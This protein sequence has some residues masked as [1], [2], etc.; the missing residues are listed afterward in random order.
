TPHPSPPPRIAL[1]DFG[2]KWSILRNLEASGYEVLVFPYRTTSQEILDANCAGI[3][4]SNGPGD[5]AVLDHA[6]QEIGNLVR[7]KDHPPVLGICLGHQ[8]L[9]LAS[10][11]KTY[12]MKF[13]HHGVNHPVHDEES[14]RVWISSHNHGFSVD[15]DSLSGDAK[16]THISLNDR[17]V[18]GLEN[19]ILGYFSVQFHPESAPGPWEARGIFQK[20]KSWVQQGARNAGN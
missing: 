7:K 19:K 12:K 5:P 9:A 18:E 10:G 16:V 14:G 13:G 8:L 1:W 17:T 6:I 2:V 15:Q 11:A 4:L 3:V 20:F